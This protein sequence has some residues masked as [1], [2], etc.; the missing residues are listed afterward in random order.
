MLSIHWDDPERSK[1]MADSTGKKSLAQS[2]GI[3]NIVIPLQHLPRHLRL[4]EIKGRARPLAAID[5]AHPAQ[6][7]RR[8]RHKRVRPQLLA[9]RVRHRHG[10]AVRDGRVRR[11]RHGHGERVLRRRRHLGVDDEIDAGL[12]AD[13][14]AD[15]VGDGGGLGRAEGGADGDAVV[16]REGTGG[17]VAALGVGDEHLLAGFG[18]GGAEEFG[19][20]IAGVKVVVAGLQGGVFG[21][22][23]GEG[24]GGPAGDLVVEL[25]QVFWSMGIGTGRLTMDL[26]SAADSLGN[27]ES[28]APSAPSSVSSTVSSSVPS[29]VSSSLFRSAELPT[30]RYLQSPTPQQK[31]DEISDPEG[32]DEK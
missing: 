17:G 20:A 13:A 28:L 11:L 4:A 23:A 12:D 8:K 30:L 3:N 7:R 26:L 6:I 29:S 25:S 5:R 9:H 27:R 31:V 32:I 18:E 10:C 14:G 2:S 24:V 21:G 22:T 15:G 19:F 16:D 1:P